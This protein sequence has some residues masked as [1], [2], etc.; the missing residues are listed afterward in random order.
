MT[1]SREQA[2]GEGN[3]GRANVLRRQAIRHGKSRKGPLHLGKTIASGVGMTNDWLAEQMSFESQDLMGQA[4]S[5]ELN[6]LVPS[7]MPC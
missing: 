6:R 7:R 3:S 4:Y 2:L 5:S 1:T